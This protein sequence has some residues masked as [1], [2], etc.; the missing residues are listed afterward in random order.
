MRCNGRSPCY[1]FGMKRIILILLFLLFAQ[2]VFADF[3]PQY[4]KTIT[5]WGIGGVFVG[6]DYLIFDAPADGAKLLQ[7]TIWDEKG[8]VTC[9]G[10]CVDEALFTLFVPSKNSVI[11]SAVDENDGWAQVCYSQK[12]GKLGWIRLEGDNKFIP[13][14]Q[15][16]IKYGKPHGIYM[17]KDI[18]KDE[19][20]LYSQPEDGA[21]SVDS[22]EY[23]KQ[24]TPWYIKGNWIMVKILN[25]DNTQKTGWLK[26]RTSDG[27]LR[28]FV[29]PRK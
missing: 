18:P 16:F 27:M 4:S 13:W 12:S 26:W 5:V 9:K 7:R 22:W 1:N 29:D 28:G 24:I 11:L 15:Y 21:K 2:P 17:F 19:N 20:K 14:P 25:F 23:A 10:D 8:N 6:Q 3:V